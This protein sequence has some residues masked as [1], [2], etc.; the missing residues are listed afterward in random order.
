MR[1]AFVGKGGSGKTTFSSLFSR[2]LAL[3]RVPVVAIDADINQ[4]LGV[5]LGLSAG[6]AAAIPPLGLEIERVKEFLRGTNPR[7]SS[8]H[9]MIK[10]TP[11]GHGSRLLRLVEENP[12]YRYF[13]REI[14]G[15]RLMVTG[16]FGQEDLGQRCYH[17][18]VGAVELLLNHLL[19][20]K[21]EYLVVDMTAGAD[22]FASGMFTKFDLT[23]LVVE[24]TMR[25]LGVYEQ[26]KG[27]CRD[28]DVRLCV[29]GNKVEGEE[30]LAFL[31]EHVGADLLTWFER[32]AFVRALEK[33]RTLPLEQL[34]VVHMQALGEM[35][36]MVDG[37]QKDWEKLYRQALEFHRLNALS[38]ANAAVGEDLLA[39]IDPEFSLAEHISGGMA[40]HA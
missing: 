20:G 25:S 17:S 12:I 1:V 29:V 13:E 30:D 38:W 19:D 8:E 14:N 26:Y 2:Y 22:S 10:T 33:G 11:P 5:A 39:Q 6:E 16:P 31:R 9:A 28:Y 37:C 7:I 35:K 40:T 21:N 32:S 3:Q 23:F 24:P 27:Y 15:V 36:R 18:K 34:E 4:H